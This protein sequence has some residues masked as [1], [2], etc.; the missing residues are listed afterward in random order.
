MEHTDHQIKQRITEETTSNNRDTNK[1]RE[2]VCD[3]KAGSVNKP[4][5]AKR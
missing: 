4:E 5:K 1:N 3:L 2:E